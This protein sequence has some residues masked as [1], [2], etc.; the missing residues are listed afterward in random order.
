MKKTQDIIYY[1]AQSAFGRDGT[2]M[3][4]NQIVS[5]WLKSGA[6]RKMTVEGM[7]RLPQGPSDPYPISY[8]PLAS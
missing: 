8:V 1:G 3:P 7:V 2:A 6:V 5:V 4:G